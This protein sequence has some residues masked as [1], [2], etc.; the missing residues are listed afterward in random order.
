MEA[1]V[2]ASPIWPIHIGPETLGSSRPTGCESG[3]KQ[4]IGNSPES[5]GGKNPAEI[6]ASTSS[7][8]G[9]K[10]RQPK[11]VSTSFAPCITFL[12][13]TE[14]R[15]WCE[16]QIERRGS[17]LRSCRAAARATVAIRTR[18]PESCLSLSRRTLAPYLRISGFFE[19]P[20]NAAVSVALTSNTPRRARA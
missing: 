2:S 4:R 10:I 11:D 5:S 8:V 18:R 15:R 7:L 1:I 16:S 20:L 9:E 12:T 6:D 14:T 13:R 19:E 3:R 17:I